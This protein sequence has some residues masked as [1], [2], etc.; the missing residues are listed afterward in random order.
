MLGEV[1]GEI[2]IEAKQE[3]R[4]LRITV[5]DDGPGF[6]PELLASGIRPYFST[7]ERGTGLGLAMVSRFTR[8]VG[9]SLDLANRQPRGAQ[10]TLVLPAD[11]D[12][13]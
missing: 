8:D 5:S 13:A 3:G 10:V 12:A 1:G 11:G 7:R 2:V 4:M 9:G 6:P